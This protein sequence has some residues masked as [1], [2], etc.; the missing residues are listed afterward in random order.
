MIPRLLRAALLILLA[1]T[2]GACTAGFDAQWKTA[3]AHRAHDRFA[4]RWAGEWRSTRGSHHGALECVFTPSAPGEYTA[5][6]HAHWGTLSDTYTVT[7]KTVPVKGAL[8]F[9]GSKDLGALQG[10]TYKYD[11]LVT[12]QRFTAHYDSAYDT[13]VFELHRVR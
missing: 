10:G 3:A 7:F 9:T 4:G 5:N 1:I 6:F 11:G 13:G 12:P 2:L 8:R